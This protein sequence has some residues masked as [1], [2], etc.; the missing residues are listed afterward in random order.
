MVENQRQ[1]QF[2]FEVDAKRYQFEG[3]SK[4][5]IM[6]NAQTSN[7]PIGGYAM[8]GYAGGLVR[9]ALTDAYG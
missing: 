2:N 6:A 9:K 4:K 5:N 1:R 8:N 7:I 3:P